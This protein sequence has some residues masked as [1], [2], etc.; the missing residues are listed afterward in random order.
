VAH[1]SSQ[2]QAELDEESK[3]IEAESLKAIQ[4]LDSILAAITAARGDGVAMAA[5]AANLKTAISSYQDKWE[6]MGKTVRKLALTAA[7][8]YG[9]PIPG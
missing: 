8:S 9:L 7:R 2:L 5:A 1:L 6:N 3:S 4:E